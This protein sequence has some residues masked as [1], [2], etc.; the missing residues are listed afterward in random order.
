MT[1][2]R[3]YEIAFGSVC[4][5]VCICVCVCKERA[6]LTLA[7]T[8]LLTGCKTSSI[9]LSDTDTDSPH[10]HTH[11]LMRTC[12]HTQ[13]KKN[14]ESLFIVVTFFANMVVNLNTVTSIG[15]LFWSV[16]VCMRVNSWT[17]LGFEGRVMNAVQYRVC[18]CLSWTKLGFEGSYECSVGTDSL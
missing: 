1:N 16:W 17:E 2:K 4:V 11:G 12:T 13:Y 7:E 18:M 6:M 10:S 9:Y 5:C 3:S 14:T 15:I 8:I